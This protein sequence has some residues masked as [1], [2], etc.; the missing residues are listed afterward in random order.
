MKPLCS[1]SCRGLCPECGANLNTA[2]CTCQ[3]AWVDPRLAVL[4]Q[5]RKDK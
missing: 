1:E 2:S 5:L 4:E 3:R